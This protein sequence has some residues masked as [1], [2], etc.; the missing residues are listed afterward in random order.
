MKL[1]KLE[2]K[3]YQKCR[4]RLNL[5]FCDAISCIFMASCQPTFK[6]KKWNVN[7]TYYTTYTD[8]RHT[9]TVVGNPGGVIGYFWQIILRGVL[10]VV[11]KS[12]GGGGSFLLHFYVE[13]FKNL[14][15]G[16]MRC[17]PPPSP[18]PPVCI[19][20]LRFLHCLNWFFS[21]FINRK[22]SNKLKWA[23]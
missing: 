18:P 21:W 7:Q 19:Y 6:F 23:A 1:L 17:P 11:R 10:G 2:K 22:F 20:D 16:Y 14:D 8:L 3:F 13:V 12:V 9:C 15:R 5:N 4:Q